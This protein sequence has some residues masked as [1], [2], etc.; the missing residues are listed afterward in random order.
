MSAQDIKVVQELLPNLMAG[1]K[2]IERF[3]KNTKIDSVLEMSLAWG[4]GT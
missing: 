2:C 1:E 3:K 4:Y